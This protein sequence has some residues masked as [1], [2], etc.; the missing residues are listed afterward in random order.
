VRNL[1]KANK[2][3]VTHAIEK[4]VEDDEFYHEHGWFHKA[5]CGELVGEKIGEGD[6]TCKDC[7]ATLD[8]ANDRYRP[9]RKALEELEFLVG[10]KP[11]GE[12]LPDDIRARLNVLLRGEWP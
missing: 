6:P 11:E 8:R 9:I 7:L 1:A 3:R 4:R 2:G 10:C 5:V 12:S